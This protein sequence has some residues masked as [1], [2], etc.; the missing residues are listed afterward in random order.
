MILWAIGD[1]ITGCDSFFALAVYQLRMFLATITY[2]SL[3]R[4]FFFF[5]HSKKPE[6]K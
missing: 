4:F 1:F 3:S 6:N 5:L 2:N